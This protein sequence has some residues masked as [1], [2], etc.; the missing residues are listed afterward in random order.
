MFLTNKESINQPGTFTV[1]NGYAD[2]SK[3]DMLFEIATDV[4]AEHK[5]IVFITLEHDEA[6]VIQCMSDL[7]I[8]NTASKKFLN[9]K[10]LPNKS[11]VGDIV[12]YVGVV[13]SKNNTIVDVILVDGLDLLTYRMG[14]VYIPVHI[15]ST[16]N[17]EL[18]KYVKLGNYICVGTSQCTSGDT[19][20][21]MTY[22]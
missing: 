9:I 1:I 13:E 21:V 22:N 6:Y 5:N 16:P 17:T 8:S 14:L 19:E 15:R 7:G 2:G 20:S 10:C 3:T 18:Q 11:T 4:I 12:Q